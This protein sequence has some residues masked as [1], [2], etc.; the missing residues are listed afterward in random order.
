MRA[1]RA[2]VVGFEYYG[3]FLARLINEQSD[4][5][6]L[7][8]YEGSRLGT[9]QAMIAACTADAIITFGGPAPNAALVE[10]ARR[11]NIPVITIWAGSDVLAAQDEPQLLELLKSYGFIHLSDGP[12]LVDELRALDIESEYVPVTAIVPAEQP[13]PMPAQFSVLACLPEPRR[14]F[15]GE[16]A[17]YELAREFP[18]IP[19]VVVGR[20]KPN[21]IAPPNVRFTGVVD[22]M[23]RYIDESSV[24]LRLPV[25]DGKSM[26]VLEALARG[27]H[28]IWNYDFPGVTHAERT[29]DAIDQMRAFIDLHE[30]G[31]L[32]VNHA[33]YDYARKNF[34]RERLA[35]AFVER[36][37]QARPRAFSQAPMRVAISGLTLFAAQLINVMQQHPTGWRAQMMRI[38]ARL[39]VVTS[40]FT[41]L[42]SDVWYSI[43]APIGDR[44]LHLWARILRKPRVIHWVGS[45]IV[46]L[47][48]NRRL[49]KLCSRPGVVNL[50]EVDWT[51]EELRKLGITASLAPLPPSFTAQTPPP[52]PESF[53]VL[54]YLPRSRGEFYGRR[55]YERLIRA[56]MNEDVT[57]L[58]VGGGEF[59]APPE[60]KVERLGWRARLEDVYARSSVLVRFTKHDGLSIMTL[61]ALINGRYVLWSQDFPY[62][63]QV[64][65]YQEIE[66]AIRALLERH[67]RGDLPAQHEAA[68]YVV[69]TYDANRCVDRIALAWRAACEE[70]ARSH[71]LVPEAR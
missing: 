5:W 57:F 54:L 58:V 6:H 41:L 23:P 66:S 51:I 35:A 28:V 2:I 33:G 30:A 29:I 14:P 38:N 45:D 16:R 7:R 17:V 50:A 26:L 32:D 64:R 65:S 42:S 53:T 20:G 34:T 15:Y 60:A 3:R 1:R 8:F 69:E 63:T 59:Y 43:G 13:A 11:R 47:Y 71:A 25:H 52:M 22:D 46:E 10:I 44:W 49:R 37:N 40:M 48:R 61:E 12:W 55:E 31:E 24:L 19:F 62:A 21:P 27:R 70:P 56:F 36:L 9:L 68:S 4:G 39:E 18:Q 67:R